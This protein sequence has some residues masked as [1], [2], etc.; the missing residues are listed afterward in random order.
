MQK[1]KF[2]SGVFSLFIF[3]L[4]SSAETIKISAGVVPME[5]VFKKIQ[6]PFEKQTGITLVLVKG[7]HVT[8]LEDLQNGKAEVASVAFSFED[9]L[10]RA[11]KDGLVLKNKSELKFRVIG[12]DNAKFIAN[13]SNPMKS[14][15]FEQLSRIFTGAVKNWK[16]F[17]GPDQK[18]TVVVSEKFPG[19]N[20]LIR[21][22]VMGGADFVGAQKISG[23]ADEVK[24]I[25]AKNPGAISF[26][27]SGA[28][29]NQVSVI[30][31][32]E[33]GRP[34][35]AATKGI[36]SPKVLKLFNFLSENGANLQS[37]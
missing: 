8:S 30:Q 35:V 24:Q 17:G 7:T 11:Q 27:P 14:L 20:G 37:H 2:F 34:I 5:N 33:I 32:P 31:A 12:R 4:S 1:L 26:L 16:E 10:V 21:D 29:D 13:S 23:E 36:P 19:F 6:G 25:I 18:I 15:S 22:K 28:V 9:W 3:G